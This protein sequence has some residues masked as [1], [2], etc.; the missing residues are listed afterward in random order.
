MPKKPAPERTEP[1][2]PEA[3]QSHETSIAKEERI[4]RIIKQHPQ[5]DIP[6]VESVE[7]PEAPL[8]E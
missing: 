7:P 8:K 1:I 6:R 2:E 4:K 5:R 3:Q